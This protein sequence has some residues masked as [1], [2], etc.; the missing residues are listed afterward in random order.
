MTDGLTINQP[1][2]HKSNLIYKKNNQHT[3]VPIFTIFSILIHF[4]QLPLSAGYG[5]ENGLRCITVRK[6]HIYICAFWV[7]TSDISIRA[8]SYTRL[9]GTNQLRI[10]SNLP[11]LTNQ[12]QNYY[13][14]RGL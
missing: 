7:N 1:T 10:L 4:S 5:P 12:T 13:S 11:S 6:Q 8:L 14:T 9:P 2:E 3:S